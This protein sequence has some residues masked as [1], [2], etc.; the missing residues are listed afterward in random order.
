MQPHYHGV[1]IATVDRAVATHH[2][3]HPCHRWMHT[4]VTRLHQEL[5]LA[6]F[7]GTKAVNY[8]KLKII[9]LSYIQDGR[10]DNLGNLEG[11]ACTTF[12]IPRSLLLLSQHGLR[13][14][15]RMHL[16]SH[17]LWHAGLRC[18]SVQIKKI[19]M[20]EHSS[21]VKTDGAEQ[22][23]KKAPSCSWVCSE[24]T[25][26]EPAEEEQD[27]HATHALRVT[28][29]CVKTLER[30]YHQALAYI[31][32]KLLLNHLHLKKNIK[33][34]KSAC[35]YSLL[36]GDNIWHTTYRAQSLVPMWICLRASLN[37]VGGS[38]FQFRTIVRV[39]LRVR[40]RYIPFR[41]VLG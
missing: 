25:Q 37:P 40:V 3:Q 36:C 4:G 33:K 5:G 11:G 19:K 23:K 7:K 35:W 28:S 22:K 30:E 29:L 31:I 21:E 9:S 18:N 8:Q 14:K 6:S 41:L 26:A 16:N 24:S 39:E 27:F 2:Q 20:S 38:E 10:F 1:A 15:E 34:N 12:S 32:I 13:R 17:V